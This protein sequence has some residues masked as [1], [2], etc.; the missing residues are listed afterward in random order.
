MLRPS[1]APK[2]GEGVTAGD[3]DAAPLVRDQLARYLLDESRRDPRCALVYL[4]HHAI[5]PDEDLRASLECL[6][7]GGGGDLGDR[8]H[9]LSWRA[10][11]REIARRIAD[12]AP[13]EGVRE[14]LHRARMFWFGGVTL[15]APLHLAGTPAFYRTAPISYPWSPPP[16]VPSR[17]LRYRR[18]S[19]AAEGTWSPLTRC[20]GPS[21]FYGEKN[22]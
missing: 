14:V 6:R 3:D 22:Q 1:W 20:L 21:G 9:W 2:S 4:T 8:V 16:P 11:E 18:R 5:R 17:G 12:G 10:L 13:Y 7:Q 15:G 19:A